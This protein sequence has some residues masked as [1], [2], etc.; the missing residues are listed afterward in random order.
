MTIPLGRRRL[1]LT[2]A[3]APASSRPWDGAAAFGATDARLASFATNRAGDVAGA[4]REALRP[5]SAGA[6]RP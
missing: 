1:V 3:M 4:H 5:M 2:V 6:R